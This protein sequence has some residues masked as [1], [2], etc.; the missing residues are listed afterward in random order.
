M[1]PRLDRSCAVALTAVLLSCEGAYLTAPPDSTIVLSANPSFV[2]AHGGIS[3]ITAFVIEPA[4]TYVPDGTV[5]R[6][7]TDLGRIDPETRTRRGVATARFVSDSRSGN[8]LIRAF[9]GGVIGEPPIVITVGNA[10]V[11][12]IRLRA[13]PSRITISNSTHVIATVVDENGNPVPNV[14]VTFSV[15]DNPAT[16]FFDNAGAPIFT[17]NNGEAEDV[18]R[19]RRNTV[20]VAEVQ[21]T[22]PNG[23]GDFVT[24]DNPL[25]IPI[26]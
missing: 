25:R 20:G 16:E 21:A 10:R 4:G 6:W 18:L 19:T 23:T 9:S 26:L 17:N 22:A 24:A 7:T 3:E 5:V 12:A 11:A 1:R 2:A 15:V 14:P 8:A 13:V